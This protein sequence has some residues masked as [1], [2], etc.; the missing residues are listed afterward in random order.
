MLTAGTM[1]FVERPSRIRPF[2]ADGVIVVVRW[3]ALAFAALQT[4]TY[5]RPIPRL[6]QP[7][8]TGVIVVFAAA[9]VALTAWWWLLR[10]RETRATTH[11]DSCELQRQRRWLG[12]VS[13]L[14]DTTFA[15][16]LCWIYAFDSATAIFVVLYLPPVEAAVRFGMRT[17]LATMLV[18]TVAYAARDVWASH[19]Y[20]IDWLS[21]SISFRTGVGMLIAGMAGAMADRYERAHNQVSEALR[22][23]QEA[24]TA[25]RSLDE[26]RSTFLAAVSHELRTPLTSILG[27]ALTIQQT[28]DELRDDTRT[29]LEYVVGESRQLERLLQD[30]LDIERT[31]RGGV[32]L[33]RQVT[34]VTTI[35]TRLVERIERRLGRAVTFDSPTPVTGVLDEPKAERIIDN[36]LSNAVKYSPNGS[37]VHVQVER[38]G[39]GVMITVVDEGPGVPE[40]LRGSI[41]QPFERGLVTTAHKPG[42]GIGLSLVDRFA[43]LHGGRAWVDDRRDR[44]GSAFH[45]YLPDGPEGVAMA[46][47]AD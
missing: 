17:A 40:A 41:F 9:C 2:N 44:S 33:D 37:A 12:C 43:R 35:V 13:L 15:V 29:M 25:L 34:D 45:V 10:R 19:H 1:R 30:L 3:V 23:E 27:F 32:S 31:G 6:V 4:A 18:E 7:W 5:Y 24:S 38:V 26:L 21:A 20:G 16:A 22:R 28:A 14:V 8:A 39:G 36:L 42:T 46:T 47:L 11:G